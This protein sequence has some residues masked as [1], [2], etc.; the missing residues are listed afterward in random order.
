MIQALRSGRSGIWRSPGRQQPIDT[1]TREVEFR[2]SF[3]VGITERSVQIGRRQN[4]P[5]RQTVCRRPDSP[6]NAPA[7]LL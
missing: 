1:W 6:G 3:A 5:R 4:C 2:R 7:E